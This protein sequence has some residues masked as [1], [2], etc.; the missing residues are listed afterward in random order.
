MDEISCNNTGNAAVFL[1]QQKLADQQPQQQCDDGQQQDGNDHRRISEY[2][3]YVRR[4]P[5]I[6]G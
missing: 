5:T 3:C 4:V 1:L 6:I 2:A